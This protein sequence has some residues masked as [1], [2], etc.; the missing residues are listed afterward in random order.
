MRLP[1]RSPATDP[2]NTIDELS[3]R[4]TSA[5]LTTMKC[6]RRLSAN[7]RSQSSGDVPAT[8]MPK[9]VPTLSTMPSGVSPD[10]SATAS[11]QPSSVVTSATTTAA[12]PP[13][14]VMRR[15]VSSTAPSSLSTQ[16]TDAPSRAARTAMA[17]P[18]PTG[19]SGSRE[20]WVPAPTTAMQRPSRSGL[21]TSGLLSVIPSS[22][23]RASGP[24]ARA[25]AHELGLGE[26]PGLGLHADRTQHGSQHHVVRDQHQQFDEA[27]LVEVLRQIRPRRVG[28]PAVL[29]RLVDGSQRSSLERGPVDGVQRGRIAAERLHLLEG[30]AAPLTHLDVLGPLVETVEAVGGAQDDD[31]GEPA[32]QAAVEERT[33]KAHPAADQLR[34]PRQR[35]EDVH[36]R[37]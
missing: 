8:P 5:R 1:G 34:R 3:G 10:S 19:A 25:A 15:Q 13:S 12:L 7:V 18:L 4:V 27:G 32:R 14:S 23:S 28:H 9:P 29:T 31:L 22:R 20:G 6:A 33:A 11:R 16:T 36:R 26:R 21:T 2:M 30:D 24:R 37:S 17:R 35:G